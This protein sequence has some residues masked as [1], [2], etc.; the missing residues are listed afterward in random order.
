MCLFFA[1]I[2]ISGDGQDGISAGGY[3]TNG[4]QNRHWVPLGRPGAQPPPGINKCSYASTC[5]P[6]NGCQNG[7]L[8]LG[9]WPLSESDIKGLN[10]FGHFLKFFASAL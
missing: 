7:T 3:I 6:R 8:K 5:F 10:S 1:V 2:P 9:G 4:H